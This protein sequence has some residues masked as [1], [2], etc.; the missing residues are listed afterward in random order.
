MKF[1]VKHY[2][3]WGGYDGKYPQYVTEYGFEFPFTFCLVQ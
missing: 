2:T 3:R 1:Y